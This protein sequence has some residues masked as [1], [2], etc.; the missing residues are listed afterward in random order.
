MST[1]PLLSLLDFT[2]PFTLETDACATGLGAVLMQHGK[3]LAFYS[4]SLGP[5]TSAQSIYEKEA[6]A[7]LEALKKWRHYFLNNKVIIKTD[8]RSLQYLGSQRL[9]EGIQHKLMLKLL[10][11]DYIIEYKKGK[12]NRVADALSRKYQQE[13]DT[14]AEEHCAAI[15]VLVP[16][17]MGEV[18]DSYRTDEACLKLQQELAIDP[19][20]NPSY[21]LQA[22]I[23]RYKGRIYIGSS[24]DLRTKIFHAFHSSVY[25]GHSGHRVTLHRIQQL[26]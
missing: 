21:S 25:G 14:P 9:L 16:A 2:S 3:P 5:K 24:T 18:I 6:L 19:A 4:K 22:G 20:S 23:I 17:W 11:F 8:Q 26:F 10:E 12:E 7:I 13:E 15:S 1:P